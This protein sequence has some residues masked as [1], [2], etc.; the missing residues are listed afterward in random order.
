MRAFL[1][2]VIPDEQRKLVKE[3]ME[4]LRRTGQSG[5][6]YTPDS[7]LHVTL[8]F[9]DAITENQLTLLENALTE[10]ALHSISS[11]RISGSGAFPFPEAPKVLWLGID[12]GRELM[13]LQEELE[14]RLESVGIPR[15]SRP[16]QPHLTLAR[17]NS[18]PSKGLTEALKEAGAL[19]IPAFRVSGVHLYGSRLLPDGVRHELLRVFPLL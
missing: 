19:E 9:M 6:R 15:E 2:V 16:Y 10:T 5:I 13:Q 8:K 1:A 18:K 17:L 7:Q 3:S 11:F 4:I 14:K 12:G